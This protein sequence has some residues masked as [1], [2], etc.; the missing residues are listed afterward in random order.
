MESMEAGK[1]KKRETWKPESI[2]TGR[3]VSRKYTDVEIN[4]SET[5]LCVKF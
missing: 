3:Y 4:G 5:L 2:K 1:C